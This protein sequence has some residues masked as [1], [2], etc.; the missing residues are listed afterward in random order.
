MDGHHC[1]SVCLLGRS[2]K[3]LLQLSA[4]WRSSLSEVLFVR[5]VWRSVI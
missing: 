3:L 5:N 1:F 4:A 2:S